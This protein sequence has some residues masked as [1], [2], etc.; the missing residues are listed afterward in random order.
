MDAKGDTK[1]ALTAIK[2][3]QDAAMRQPG[4]KIQILL[5][6]K[7]LPQLKSA[8]DELLRSVDA[9]K[10]RNRVFNTP[11]TLDELLDPPEEMEIREAE[12]F[13]T[14]EKGKEEIVN[15]VQHEM[16]VARGEVTE[17]DSDEDED[18]VE[19]CVTRVK[20]MQL[21]EELEKAVLEYAD[22]E[23]LGLLKQLCCF[24]AQL[25]KQQFTGMR[26]TT[27]HELGVSRRM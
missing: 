13:P 7:D 25:R 9:L 10:S 27:L 16:A 4:L 12:L 15:P 5:H 21:C 26:Q 20:A 22:G 24:R 23:D 1:A 17:I 8:E 2:P 14:G 6:P 19:Q 18:P 11:P 3:L